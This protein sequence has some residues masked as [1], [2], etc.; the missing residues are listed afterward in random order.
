MHTISDGERRRV[1]LVMGLMSPWEVLLLD[2]VSSSDQEAKHAS[3][4][5]GLG[6]RRSRRPSAIRSPRLSESR[7]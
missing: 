6:H 3:P 1:Q 7:V 4:T 2:E 5:P